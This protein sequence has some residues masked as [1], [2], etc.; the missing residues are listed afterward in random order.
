MF[1]NLSFQHKVRLLLAVALVAVL[2]TASLAVWMDARHIE[3]GRRAQLV[4][5]V[6]SLA[7]LVQSYQDQAAAGKLSQAD[8]QAA[9]AEA[10]K[11]ARY[12][13]ADGK[14]D[15]FYI[16][17]LDGTGVMHPIK[18]EWNGQN[19]VGKI[20]DGRGGDVLGLLQQGLR[21][22]ADGR[23]FV[24]TWFPRPGSDTPVPKLQYVVKV[25]GWDW[26]VGSGLYMDDVFAEVRATVIRGA[27]AVLLT[28]SLLVALAWTL[29][30]SVRLTLGGDPAAARA[31]VAEVAQG[32]LDVPIPAAP[33]GS[34]FDG[35]SQML[36]GLRQMVGQVRQATD[37]I[38]TASG[39]IASGNADLSQRTEQTASNLEKTASAMEQLTA[40]VRQSA[41][42]ARTANQL[43][44]SAADTARRGGEVVSQVVSTM[45]EINQSSQRIADIIGVID[46]IAFQ[47]NILAL[48]AAVEAARA[49][50]QG[51][52]FAVVAGE[53]RSLAQRSASAAKEIK[54]LIGTSVEKVESGARL[55]GDAGRTMD[56]IV[57][58]VQ[59]VTDVVGEISSAA[60]EQSQGIGDVNR[61][62]TELDQMTQQNAALVEQSAAAAESLREQAGRLSGV[63][64]GFRIGAVTLAPSP[65][66]APR[67][68]PAAPA[69]PKRSTPAAAARPAAP[70]PVAAT[71]SAD[72]GDWAT[73]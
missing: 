26:M 38:G 34:L 6:Q 60:A 23:A 62:I 73:F 39:E 69:A 65:A 54:T 50:E 72:D 22:S 33:A 15:Y 42:S 16:W 24:D 57:A 12:G 45:G 41:D 19:M 43:A 59:R 44:T 49:G 36:A 32:R 20:K 9:A 29:A 61:A 40:T 14:S 17:A 11:R 55:V 28:T 35:L 51:R 47:T 64:A 4:T 52:G 37:S 66:P 27:V 8:A 58:S 1:A 10:V 31:I 7:S 67:A 56:E 3:Q 71:A 18:P 30:R 5:A 46:G 68:A 70:A 21:N 25:P 13:G 2:G 48:N 53:V 63:V